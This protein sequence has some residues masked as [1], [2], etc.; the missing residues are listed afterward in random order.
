MDGLARGD[1]ASRY[2]AYS[3]AINGGWMCPDEARKKE[4]QNPMPDGEGK[5]YRIPVNVMPAAVAQDFW[6][7]K[8]TN[9]GGDA[10]GTGAKSKAGNSPA[11]PVS[12][13]SV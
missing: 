9:Q 8:T 2:D 7:A 11:D 10:S 4:N 6:L 5:V 13:S 1:M 3:K 12:G